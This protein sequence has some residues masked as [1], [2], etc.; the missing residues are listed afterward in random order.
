MEMFCHRLPSVIPLTNRN[1]VDLA[2]LTGA[3]TMVAPTFDQLPHT[4]SMEQHCP[5]YLT[6]GWYERDNGRNMRG[7]VACALLKALQEVGRVPPGFEAVAEAAIQGYTQSEYPARCAVTCWL[8]QCLTACRQAPEPT[9]VGAAAAGT[10]GTACWPNGALHPIT[11]GGSIHIHTMTQAAQP[12]LGEVWP[13]T[14]CPSPAPLSPAEGSAVRNTCYAFSAA[15]N[16]L[17]HSPG[18][19]TCPPRNAWT[20]TT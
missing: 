10:A 4:E 9:R 11:M 6:P 19:R 3:C 2:R 15:G 1:S 13:T 8:Q 14:R 17:T 20:T 5:G 18:P 16:N 12:P 7:H